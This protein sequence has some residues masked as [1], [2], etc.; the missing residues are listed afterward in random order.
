MPRSFSF[1]DGKFVTP[2]ITV[3]DAKQNMYL[4]YIEFVFMY[5]GNDIVGVD[6]HV[7]CTYTLASIST[8]LHAL[9]LCLRSTSRKRL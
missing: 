1:V 4:N 2:W 5:S 8:Q 3:W 9:C 6:Y 7:D